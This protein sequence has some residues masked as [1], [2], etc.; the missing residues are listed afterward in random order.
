[1]T[2]QEAMERLD[3]LVDGTLAEGEAENLARHLVACPGCREEERALREL[4]ARTASLPPEIAPQRDL[5]PG[6]ARRLERG[7]GAVVAFP[8]RW[9]LGLGGRPMLAVAA[10]AL[11]AVSSSVTAFLLR[12]PGS[13]PPTP[14]VTLQPAVFEAGEASIRSAEAEYEQ[15]ATAL[16][17]SLEA[18]R[19]SLSPQTV[20]V[21]ENNL[22]LIDA[23]LRQVRE[24]LRKDPGNPSLVRML[25]STHRKK[26]DVL[27]R[28][29]RHPISL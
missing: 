23:A 5:W 25:A 18:R 4:L 16:L 2:C 15:A 1:M 11:A 3:D 9:S 13:A 28:V 12:G 7:S 29:V 26:V 22:A 21:V 24:A 17:A 14:E 27:Q 20:A 10:V 6:I 8:P 19:A